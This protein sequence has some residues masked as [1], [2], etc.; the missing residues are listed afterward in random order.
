MLLYVSHYPAKGSRE[1]QKKTEKKVSAA[2][3]TREGQQD[4][5][6]GHWNRE[7]EKD[8]T[9]EERQEEEERKRQITEHLWGLPHAV[10]PLWSDSQVDA[11]GIGALRP[12]DSFYPF[13][14]HHT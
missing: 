10:R 13:K 1:K 2:G 11:E 6:G 9:G 5:I 12:N 3:A 7:K 14:G 8:R 4:A